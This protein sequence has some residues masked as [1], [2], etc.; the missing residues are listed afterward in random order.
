[1]FSSILLLFTGG[2]RRSSS[3]CPPFLDHALCLLLYDGV[4]FDQSHLGLNL[5]VE[6]QA[7]LRIPS[8]KVK[9]EPVE[10]AP[11]ADLEEPPAP[12]EP[13]NTLDHEQMEVMRENQERMEVDAELEC[14]SQ[15]GDSA[16]EQLARVVSG[17]FT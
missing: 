2:V 13:E 10:A 7:E 3:Y 4:E 6:F 17:S 9:S 1:M 12:A 8:P 16:D 15:D 14:A 5:P 11:G